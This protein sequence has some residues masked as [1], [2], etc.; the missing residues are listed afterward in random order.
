MN[1]DFETNPVT[2]LDLPQKTVHAGAPKN[3]APAGSLLCT[4][5]GVSFTAFQRL[6]LSLSPFVN[7][8]GIISIELD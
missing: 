1:P 8:F 4:G 6:F 7:Y 2:Y 3:Y 5:R